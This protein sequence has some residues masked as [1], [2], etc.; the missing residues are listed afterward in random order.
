[1]ADSRFWRPAGP[2]VKTCIA[3]LAAAFPTVTV[4]DEMP[5]VRPLRMI[6]VSQ[7]NGARP[8]PVSSV[9]RLLIEIYAPHTVVEQMCAD[10][11]AAL[12]NS[13]GVAFGGV[14]SRGWSGEQGPV[15]YPDPDVTDLSRWQF[16]GDLTL[17]VP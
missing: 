10:A 4:S 15:D 13:G 1:M 12:R 2:G 8:N 9:H 6:R 11:S 5:K 17:A 16:H 3:I 7:V 14:F